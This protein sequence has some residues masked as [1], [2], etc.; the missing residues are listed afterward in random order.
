V[1]LFAKESSMKKSLLTGVLV[2]AVL[3]GCSASRTARP[4][5]SYRFDYQAAQSADGV[6]RAF[7]DGR[8]TIVQ[9]VN[10]SESAPIFT[11]SDGR[12]I[13]YEVQGQYAVFPQ[14]EPMFTVKTPTGVAS[15]VYTGN[16]A[17]LKNDNP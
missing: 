5:S 16:A 2:I 4:E 10:L 9:F 14:I 1:D 8:Q 17:V 3:S 15:F 13:P 12:M 6:I 7:D 11:G